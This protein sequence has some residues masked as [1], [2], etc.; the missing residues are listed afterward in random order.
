[1]KAGDTVELKL[2]L[3]SSAPLRGLP[4]ELAFAKDKLQ[5]LDVQEGEF[6]RQGGAATSFSKSGDGKDGQLRVG[7]L[8]N[9][10]TGASGDGIVLTLRFKALA[11]GLAEVRIVSA[12]PI[13]LGAAAAA[14]TLP[15]VLALQVK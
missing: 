4:I 7:V 9:Q 3:S 8:R 12:Q 5:L 1:V 15:P 2:A 6:F 13:G 11:A 14:P 10:G